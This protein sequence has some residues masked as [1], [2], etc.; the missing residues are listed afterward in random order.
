MITR[1]WRIDRAI[2]GITVAVVGT[3]IWFWPIATALELPGAGG[4]AIG[5]LLFAAGGWMIPNRFVGGMFIG[6]AFA[7]LL[8]LLLV[9][10]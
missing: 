4:W 8:P 2:I 3:A 6:F 7:C 5:W 10:R 9:L 1:D